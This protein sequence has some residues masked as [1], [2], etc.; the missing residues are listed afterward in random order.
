M[1]TWGDSDADVSQLS[2]SFEATM[3]EVV[4]YCERIQKASE[5]KELQLSEHF[6]RS[7]QASEEEAHQLRQ[8]VS[9]VPDLCMILP[10]LSSTFR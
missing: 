7:H 5:E 2:K 3:T 4:A 9:N 8:Q 10:G 1:C 6:A